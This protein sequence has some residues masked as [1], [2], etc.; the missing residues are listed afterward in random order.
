MQEPE[1]GERRE[2]SHE[3]QSS[4]DQDREHLPEAR[5]VSIDTTYVIPGWMFREW[6]K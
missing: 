6:Q 5:V 1:M 3:V 2:D 4:T